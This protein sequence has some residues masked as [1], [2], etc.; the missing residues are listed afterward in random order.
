LCDTAAEFRVRQSQDIAQHPQY[1]H[2][3]RHIDRLRLAVYIQFDHTE[4]QM[5]R[6]IAKRFSSA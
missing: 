2:T 4:G 6:S 1:R 5:S 3:R